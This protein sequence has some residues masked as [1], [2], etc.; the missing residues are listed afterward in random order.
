MAVEAEVPKF[1]R[2][3]ELYVTVMLVLGIV[4]LL[5][6]PL[7]GHYRGLYLCLTLGLII[8]IVSAAYLPIIHTKRA[9]SLRDVAI[10]SMQSLWVSTSMG[11]G[12]IVT[13]LAEYF[14]IA[15]PVAAT[16]FI[17]GWIMLL[18]GL[19]TLL[20]ISKRAKAPL[21]I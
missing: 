9:E 15:L 14:K 21:A 13:S 16:L 3:C 18:F 5:L 11:I 20:T 7:T 12:Y 4:T 8:V 2:L 1:R 10:P 17:I 19:Y 6:A